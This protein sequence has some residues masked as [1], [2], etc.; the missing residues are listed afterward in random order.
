MTQQTLTRIAKSFDQPDEVKHM[1]RTRVEIVKLGDIALKRVTA[2]PGWRWS[3]DVKPFGGGELC[4]TA[5]VA[6]L[7]SGRL[8]ASYPDGGRYEFE[9]GSAFVAPPGHDGYVIGNQPAVW[10]ELA[11]T[12]ALRSG[13]PKLGE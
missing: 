5:H 9:A 12:T 3:E 2:Q 1:G 11:D 7:V 10:F 13:F 4:Q 8:G 6:Y